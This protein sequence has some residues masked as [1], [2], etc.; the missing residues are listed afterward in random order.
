MSY[1]I[2]DNEYKN[3]ELPTGEYTL[4]HCTGMAFTSKDEIKLLNHKII[5]EYAQYRNIIQIQFKIRGKRNI[6][7]IFLKPS[8]LFLKGWDLGFVIDTELGCFSGN[9]CINLVGNPIDLNERIMSL[10]VYKLSELG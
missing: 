9:A 7:E 5:E 4:I 3:N 10:N 2:T 8:M 6:C 1:Y